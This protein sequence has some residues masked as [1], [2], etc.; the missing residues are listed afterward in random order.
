MSG[1]PIRFLGG[2]LGL[3]TSAATLKRL[4]PDLRAALETAAREA[5]RRQRAMGPQEDSAAT[6]QL[7]KNGMKIRDVDG[8]ALRPAAERL[9]ETEARALGATRWLEAIRG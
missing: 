9:W 7:S 3:W 1:R 5:A 8:R 4:P 6:E 2:V